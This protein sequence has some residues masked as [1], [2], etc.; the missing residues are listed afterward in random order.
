M[1]TK[2]EAQ[3]IVSTNVLQLDTDGL[4]ELPIGIV[5]ID[6]FNITNE[7]IDFPVKLLGLIPLFNRQRANN[8]LLCFSYFVN[9]DNKYYYQ[10]SFFAALKVIEALRVI[11]DYYFE[12]DQNVKDR[13]SFYYR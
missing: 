5:E 8:D 6:N 4:T 9:L 3:K 2:D 11:N 7:Q 1:M 13:F 12:T 10:Y